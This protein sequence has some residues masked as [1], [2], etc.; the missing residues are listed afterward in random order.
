MDSNMKLGLP[1]F[2]YQLLESK[3]VEKETKLEYKFCGVGDSVEV[4]LRWTAKG[5]MWEQ[6]FSSKGKYKSPASVKRDINRKKWMTVN[7]NSKAVSTD[8]KYEISPQCKLI[9]SDSNSE[10]PISAP[11]PTKKKTI[12]KK[13]KKSNKSALAGH[14]M[15][16]RSGQDSIEQKRSY[17]VESEFGQM[18]SP[19]EVSPSSM[20]TSSAY[21][22]DH[23]SCSGT[24]RQQASWS[25]NSDSVNMKSHGNVIVMS[26]LTEDSDSD[27][28]CASG[29]IAGLGE[30][31]LS[32]C[33]YGTSVDCTS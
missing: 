29:G 13:S 18:C 8:V 10:T 5:S 25:V 20:D 22:L 3:S 24:S 28:S 14:G 23:V 1:D 7:K 6:P 19:M 21:S 9:E 2:I 26:E 16:L 31:G 11:E 17:S 4:T 15:V 27:I 30:C 32:T 33:V 12:K